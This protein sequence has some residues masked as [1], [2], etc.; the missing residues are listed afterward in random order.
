MHELLKETIRFVGVVVA[1]TA[2]SLSI[3][4]DDASEARAKGVEV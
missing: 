2:F 3:H 1:A 4:A